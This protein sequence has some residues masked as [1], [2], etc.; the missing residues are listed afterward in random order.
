MVNDPHILGDTHVPSLIFQL[1]NLWQQLCSVFDLSAETDYQTSLGSFHFIFILFNMRF[2]SFFFFSFRFYFLLILLSDFHWF[3][4]P[5]SLIIWN[6][7]L[8]NSSNIFIT[9]AWKALLS[10][11][12][13]PA[14][15]P[16]LLPESAL[17]LDSTL[18]CILIILIFLYW[19]LDISYNIF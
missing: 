2:L 5:C 14:H 16:L 8:F 11:T 6:I 1:H 9:D 4:L 18:S 13:R 19:T 3:I 10:Q 12:S 15:R 7:V 17:A